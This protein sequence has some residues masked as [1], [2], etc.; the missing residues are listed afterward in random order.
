[1]IILLGLLFF[2]FLSVLLFHVQ[3]IGGAILIGADLVIVDFFW[4][5]LRF[6]ASNKWGTKSLVYGMLG[7]LLLRTASIILFFKFGAWWLGF[8]TIAF[9]VLLAFLLFI[10]LMSI[11]E[12]R[13]FKMETK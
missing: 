7:G 4:Q 12:A 8:H 5:W 1:M 11:I 10:P 2:S 6:Q 9:D 13:K 3:G